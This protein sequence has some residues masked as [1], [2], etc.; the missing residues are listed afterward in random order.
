VLDSS[1]LITVAAIAEQSDDETPGVEECR[2]RLKHTMN[3]PSDEETLSNS[4]VQENVSCLGRGPFSD[5]TGSP[6]TDAGADI[7]NDI[8][9]NSSDTA[10]ITPRLAECLVIDVAGDVSREADIQRI[11]WPRV[12]C[13]LCQ[14]VSDLWSKMENHKT[15]NKQEQKRFTYTCWQCV[16]TRE[17]LPDENAARLLICETKVNFN[18]RVVRCQTHR[19]ANLV[20]G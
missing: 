6:T 17:R 14:D 18:S 11:S 16:M 5:A 19:R 8:S 7:G 3:V 20:W 2:L 10:G 4:S 9:S 1:V 13:D 12:V 15:L